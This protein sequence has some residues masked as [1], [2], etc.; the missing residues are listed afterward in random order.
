MISSF[1]A[2]RPP[3]TPANKPD[4]AKQKKRMRAGS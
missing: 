3:A 4:S 1:N 2:C